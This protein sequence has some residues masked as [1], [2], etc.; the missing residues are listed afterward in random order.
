MYGTL[1]G[2]L[3][4]RKIRYDRQSYTTT[5]DGRIVGSGKTIRI[6]SIDLHYDLTVPPEAREA[7]IRALRVHPQGCPAHESV[8][9]AITIRWDAAL[10]IGDEV[11]KLSSS[12]EEE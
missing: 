1:A 4:G 10:H 3:S 2:A 5:V 9:A 8:K 11:I 12:D 6:E 7:S